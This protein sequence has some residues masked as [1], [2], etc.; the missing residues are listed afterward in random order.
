MS[1]LE[2]PDEVAAGLSGLFTDSMPTSASHASAQPSHARS[3][4][5][6]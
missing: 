6:G 1:P 2:R 5:A 3:E 4:V